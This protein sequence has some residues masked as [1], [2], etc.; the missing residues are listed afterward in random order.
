MGLGQGGNDR[1]TPQ[2]ILFNDSAKVGMLIVETAQ[3]RSGLR[4]EKDGVPTPPNIPFLEINNLNSRFIGLLEKG[5]TVSGSDI[6]NARY[7]SLG[8]SLEAGLQVVGSKKIAE[9]LTESVDSLEEIRLALEE[10][11]SFVRQ[12]AVKNP[13]L[14]NKVVDE[15]FQLH[16][17]EDTEDRPLWATEIMHT[18]LKRIYGKIKAINQANE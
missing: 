6:E 1:G 8:L 13:D 2:E 17:Q 14:V 5:E 11:E 10:A 18:A 16:G 12:E 4:I 7:A 3:K 15:V 9:T